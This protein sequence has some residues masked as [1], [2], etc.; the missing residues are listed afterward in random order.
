MCVLTGSALPERCGSAQAGSEEPV[1]AALELRLHGL[2][3]RGG[4]LLGHGLSRVRVHLRDEPAIPLLA[5]ME[6]QPARIV[7]DHVE[8]GRRQGLVGVFGLGLGLGL[9]L[10]YRVGLG[11]EGLDHLVDLPAD[12]EVVDA[13]LRVLEVTDHRG[14]IRVLLPCCEQLSLDVVPLSPACGDELADEFVDGLHGAS[15]TRLVFVEG[16]LGHCRG[17]GASMDFL[18]S[19]HPEVRDSLLGI[20]SEER[21]AAGE[22]LLQAGELGVDVFLVKTGCLELYDATVTPELVM[23]DVPI[24]SLVGQVSFLDDSPCPSDVRAER[25]STVLRW[26]RDVLRE[27]LEREPQVA[28]PFYEVLARTA[29]AR[30]RLDGPESSPVITAAAQERSERARRDAARMIKIVAEDFLSIETQLR[31][32]RDTE[33]ARRR[34]QSLLGGLEAGVSELFED[35]S[36]PGPAQAASEVVVQALRPWLV[37]SALAESCLRRPKGRVVTEEVLKHVL[38]NTESGD[39]LGRVLDRWLLDRESMAALRQ[40]LDQQAKTAGALLPDR[41]GR[42]VLVVG[43]GT[44][45]LAG[46]LQMAMRE[47]GGMLTVIDR[48]VES[49]APVEAARARAPKVSVRSQTVDLAAFAMGRHLPDLARQDLIV[50]HTLTEYLPDRLVVSFIRALGYYLTPSGSMVVS[51]LTPSRDDALFR[52]VLGWGT[53]R[54]TPEELEALIVSGGLRVT[55]AE[56]VR[57]PGMVLTATAAD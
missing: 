55:S 48:Q 54:R 39:G 1:G 47:K 19:F 32:D 29:L 37:R 35:H 34:V 17:A 36:Q 53:V 3:L 52:H 43:A 11:R 27:L 10:G 49:L 40:L 22:R 31:R 20:A 2:D 12:L 24:G 26:R 57:G 23:A 41:V 21:L 14:R 42:R 8:V 33:G 6:H 4:D 50:V 9:G 15:R 56:K 25:D 44:G 51:G 7:V 13:A 18:A 5:L 28:A 30:M 16:A 46:T 38:F 45:N